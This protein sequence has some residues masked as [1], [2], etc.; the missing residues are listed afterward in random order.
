M[1]ENTSTNETAHNDGEAAFDISAV[2]NKK[3]E[4]VPKDTESHKEQAPKEHKPE[5]SEKPKPKVEID[6]DEE[7]ETDSKSDKTDKPKDNQQD[8]KS[9]QK[10]ESPEYYKSELEKL[11]KS[12]KD[13]QKAFHEN[14]KQLAA[15]KKAVEK[16]KS[17]GTLMDEEAAMLLDH[18]Q[19]NDE[20]EGEK[21]PLVRYGDIWDKEIQYMRKYS[22]NPDEINQQVLAFQHLMQSAS[23]DEAE[24]ILS[25]LAEYEDDEVALTK[26]MLEIGRQYNDDIYADIHES[27]SI[28]KLKDKY[29]KKEKELQ[30]RLDKMER[31]YNKLKEKLEDYDDEPSDYG[32]PSGGSKGDIPKG[33]FDIGKVFDKR[34]R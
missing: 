18:T 23:Y 33:N 13:T 1:V 29:T 6:D 25:E 19:Y 22:N 7:D 24:E 14:R 26:H 8:D 9:E 5:R 10:K 20:A 30:E 31:K 16:M 34:Y 12:S 3:P 21:P 15:Y 32:L 4:G 27:G 28:R 2:F 11:Q 17:E